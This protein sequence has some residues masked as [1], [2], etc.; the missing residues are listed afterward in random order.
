M[1]AADCNSHGD[2]SPPR[3]RAEA[4]SG[5]TRELLGAEP[6]PRD[7][8]YFSGIWLSQITCDTGSIQH[9]LV[10]G[11]ARDAMGSVL[12]Q[13]GADPIIHRCVARRRV[14]RGDPHWTRSNRAKKC[15]FYSIGNRLRCSHRGLLTERWKKA[16]TSWHCQWKNSVNGQ[17]FLARPRV[18]N[19]L[20][21]RGPS[22]SQSRV[23]NAQNQKVHTLIE[24][25]ENRR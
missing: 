18:F 19:H 10:G 4:I 22:S 7:F 16:E 25:S 20:R 17:T 2:C 9:I 3:C 5:N 12:R 24:E 13:S 8:I 15:D 23:K 21:I 14:G 11:A 1:L 6:N